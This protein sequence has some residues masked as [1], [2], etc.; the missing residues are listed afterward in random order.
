MSMTRHRWL[1][2]ARQA[3]SIISSSASLFTITVLKTPY[4]YTNGFGFTKVKWIILTFDGKLRGEILT[5][6]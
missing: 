4:T 1:V 2:Q 3:R 5:M 6:D